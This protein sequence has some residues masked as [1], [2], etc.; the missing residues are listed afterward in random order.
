MSNET[1]GRQCTAVKGDK[2]RCRGWAGRG[3]DYCLAHDPARSEQATAAR[4]SG[5]QKY[6]PRDPSELGPPPT[7]AA[8]LR[9]TVA[10]AIQDVR[11][12]RLDPRQAD[13]IAKLAKV[14]REL[15]RIE[16]PIEVDS[17][18][19]MTEDEMEVE[20]MMGLQLIDRGESDRCQPA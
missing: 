10:E 18:G 4:R 9:R 5:G 8:E 17:S 15:L 19:D 2:T 13:A 6:T 12:G 11:A 7:T 1:N 20:A 14:Q 16:S 3:S